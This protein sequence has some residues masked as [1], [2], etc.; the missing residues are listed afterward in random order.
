MIIHTPLD[1]PKIEPDSMTKF[2][3]IWDK[4]ADNLT[5]VK[6][7]HMGSQS[8]IGST[9]IW[10]GL[11]IILKN[12]LTSHQ[13]PFY[14]IKDDL[15]NFYNSLL[16]LPIP[17]IQ[18]V[19]IVQSL[20]DIPS[21]SDNNLDKWELRAMLHYPSDKKQWYYTKP[22]QKEKHYMSL[23]N[24][25]MWFAYNDRY[26]WHGSDYDPQHK[27]LLLQVYFVGSIMPIIDKSILKY[28]NWCIDL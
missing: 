23:P 6:V 8:S 18:R 11:D 3:E 24:D 14:N 22:N 17:Y 19:R 28:K 16:N 20:K 15:P 9:D 12:G 2:N 1:L 10:I 26:S 25:T 4:Y 7:N 27:K 21:H 5:K 13:A